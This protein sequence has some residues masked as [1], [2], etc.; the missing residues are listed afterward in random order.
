LYVARVE[1][2]PGIVELSVQ[3][4][5]VP[6]WARVSKFSVRGEPRAVILPL[7][8]SADEGRTRAE[9]P[10]PRAINAIVRNNVKRDRD[11]DLGMDLDI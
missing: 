3:V 4:I 7:F 8:V 6:V 1:Y 11:T 2:H 5:L 10:I 9:I